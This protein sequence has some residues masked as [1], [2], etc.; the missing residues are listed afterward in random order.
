[1]A[2]VSAKSSQR[3]GVVGSQTSYVLLV[4][5]CLVLG[6]LA[7]ELLQYAWWHHELW[8][9]NLW[10]YGS[11][12]SCLSG[13]GTHPNLTMGDK[14]YMVQK[15][16]FVHHQE[17]VEIWTLHTM[18]KQVHCCNNTAPPAYFACFTRRLFVMFV[19]SFPIIPSR[20][21]KKVTVTGWG[22]DPR[23]MICFFT[24]TPSKNHQ[25]GQSTIIPKPNLTAFLRIIVLMDH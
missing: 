13:L 17:S 6:P 14:A 18:V 20:E 12:S 5:Q 1:M 25:S 24:S 4:L 23:N 2:V 11:I 22:V 8:H 10:K 16:L 3:H 15:S 21:T 9:A 19:A 7:V